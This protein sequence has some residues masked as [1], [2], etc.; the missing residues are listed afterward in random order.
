MRV[1]DGAVE[2]EP[3]SGRG[4]SSDLLF[5]IGKEAGPAKVMLSNSLK[6]G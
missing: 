3:E 4:L 1:L 6:E 5:P 2:E